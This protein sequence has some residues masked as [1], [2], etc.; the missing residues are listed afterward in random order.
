MLNK[1]VY[2]EFDFK[3]KLR[4]QL[5]WYSTENKSILKYFVEFSLFLAS[6]EASGEFYITIKKR[7][8]NAS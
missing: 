5:F 8:P 2:N 3:E 1:P 7:N 6:S 4:R